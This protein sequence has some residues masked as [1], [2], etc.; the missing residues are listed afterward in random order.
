MS[1]QYSKEVTIAQAKI[2]ELDD[3]W[4]REK[5]GRIAVISD[6]NLAQN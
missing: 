1:I 3:G 4:R 2:C 6:L 5:E